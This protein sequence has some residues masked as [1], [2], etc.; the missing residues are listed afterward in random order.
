M[1]TKRYRQTI[2]DE[3]AAHLITL[4]F[5]KDGRCYRKS[6]DT[7]EVS[8]FPL[9]R[10]FEILIVTHPMDEGWTTRSYAYTRKNIQRIPNPKEFD[11]E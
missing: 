5:S 4:G 1:P 11:N 10:R 3:L 2:K 6:V 8:V 9:K 7:K